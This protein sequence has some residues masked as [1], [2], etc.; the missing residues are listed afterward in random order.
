MPTAVRMSLGSTF[1]LDVACDGRRETWGYH[2]PE[3]VAVAQYAPGRVK[4]KPF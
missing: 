2:P 3:N 4:R 1:V